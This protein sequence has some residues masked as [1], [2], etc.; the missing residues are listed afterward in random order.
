MNSPCVQFDAKK[1]KTQLGPSV[2]SGTKG[3]PKSCANCFL[4]PA[5]HGDLFEKG[6][7]SALGRQQW[8][9]MQCSLWTNKCVYKSCRHVEGICCAKEGQLQDGI[10]GC[11]ALLQSRSCCHEGQI[12]E[13]MSQLL[14]I[15]VQQEQ[16]AAIFELMKEKEDTFG[17]M[18]EV[19]VEEQ[20]KL[21]NM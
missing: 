1:V 10:A 19:D 12:K 7:R 8:C 14:C 6:C 21:Y 2:F 3:T 4:R 13:E 17:P 11:G 5:L 15:L 9:L 18:T 20:L 16:L